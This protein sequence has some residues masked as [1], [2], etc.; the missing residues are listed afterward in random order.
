MSPIPRIVLAGGRAKPELE[1]LTGQPNRALIPFHGK[2]MLRAVVDALSGADPGAPITVV[3]D[4]PPDED[5]T[6]ICDHGG[7]VENVTAGLSAISSEPFAL[8]ATSD[9]P[10]LTPES[11]E[12]FVR[13]GLIA[14][15]GSEIGLVWPVVRVSECY[16][17][18]PG[19]KRTAIRLREGEYTGGNLMLVRP[20]ALLS[21]SRRIADAYA[22]RKSPLKIATM[23]GPG[24]LL[25]LLLS[26]SIAPTLLTIPYLE[27]QVSRILGAGA[28]AAVSS[29]PEIATDLDR[30]SD[31]EAVQ[32][33]L[34]TNSAL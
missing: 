34:S 23:M 25:R 1:K 8:I 11:V 24:P 5:Y 27:A 29:Y 9:V 26:Q 30:P 17:R 10:F 7:F 18:F 3:G 13:L 20:Q 14:A 4:V 16:A 6:S 32:R 19:V 28:R 21:N 2:T 31:F 12:E 33:W 22:A 15:Q